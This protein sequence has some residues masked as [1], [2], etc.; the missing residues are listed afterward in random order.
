MGEIVLIVDDEPAT[1]ALF[2][3]LLEI[4][5]AE[6][7]T[8]LT[9]SND[10]EAL[11]AV[12]SHACAVVI[13]D[14]RMPGI[15]GLELMQRV[16]SI[17]PDTVRIILTGYADVDIAT[18]AINSG[19][20]FRLLQKPIAGA[21]LRAEINA[22]LLHHRSLVLERTT[23]EH[24]VTGVVK[25][26]VE[27]LAAL[28]PVASAKAFR[29]QGYVSHLLQALEIRDR[30]EFELAALLLHIEQ[31][32]A[33]KIAPESAPDSAPSDPKRP[34]PPGNVNSLSLLRKIPRLK[35]VAEMI[36]RQDQP[37][38]PA[39]AG[40]LPAH[41]DRIRCGAQLLRIA[42]A[43][44]AAVQGGAKRE[45]ALARLRSR[46][47]DFDRMLVDGLTS[48]ETSDK[49]MQERAVSLARLEAGMLL[50]QDLTNNSNVLLLAKGEYLTEAMI[51]R[52]RAYATASDLKKNISVLSPAP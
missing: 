7:R 45:L 21:E 23:L 41:R 4:D 10:A 25:V 47:R 37:T 24:T 36:A 17:S 35:A 42:V 18:A 20:I 29:L 13:S 6:K 26:F 48:L 19:A 51:A 31:S 15:G 1:A 33:E 14:L 5:G 44:D 22:A 30:W 43:F 2:A 32:A 39:D 46:P 3:R 34:P 40:V 52:V 38:D 11:T 12:H 27:L 28:D 16:R 9:A 8:V 49:P 50:A